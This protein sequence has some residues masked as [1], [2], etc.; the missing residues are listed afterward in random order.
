M[1][2][3]FEVK[4]EKAGFGTEVFILTDKESGVQYFHF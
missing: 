3:R 2:N 4:K 1:D